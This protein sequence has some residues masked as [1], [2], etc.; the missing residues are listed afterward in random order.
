MVLTEILSRNARRYPDK[1]AL[2]FDQASRTFGAL[3]ERS[4]RLANALAERGVARGSNVA[5]LLY[6]RIEVVEAWFGCQKLGATPVPVNFR[7]AQ[8]E[9]EYI[10]EHSQAV[11]LISDEPLAEAAAGARRNLGGVSAHLGVGNPPDGAEGYETVLAGAAAQQPASAAREDD[12]AFLMYTSGTTGRPKGA[13][14]S[15]Q[16]I[17]AN[18][19]NWV[20]EM[21]ARQEDVWLSGL[22]LFHIGGVNGI[23]PFLYLGAT[24]VITRSTGF[25][26]GESI[27][28][29]ERHGVTMCYFVPTQWLDICRHAE[30]ARVD[31]RRLRRAMWGASPAPRS[32][33]ELLVDTFPAAEIVNAFGQTEMSSNTTFLKGADAVR[34][35]GSIGKPAINVE[36]RV[37]DDDGNDVSV[38]EIGEIVYR[39]PTVMQGYYHDSAATEEAFSG[40]WFHSGDLVYA[41]DEGFLFLTD[42]KKDMIISGGENI[43]P[44]ELERVLEEHP[45]VREAAVIGVRHRRWVETPLAVIVAAGG[46]EPSERELIE[47]CK[48]R[49][50]SYKK[51]SAI[52]LADALPRNAA[53]KVLKRELRERY[54]MMFE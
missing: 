9:L 25:D 22:P 21:G 29:L 32:T 33:L 28:L 34:K 2:V 15:Q 37:V 23:L 46:A 17:V 45:A 36:A 11:A 12:I 8:P 16:N 6:N 31:T 49:L 40:G 4:N 39:G 48:Q 7:L 51:P 24:A 13:M 14:L 30:P 53:G 19:I 52:V 18:T 50:A 3:D 42:R 10:L 38:G 41:D 44:A 43:Y 47:H 26:A 5:L 1:T 54:G 20:H 27:G 35:M